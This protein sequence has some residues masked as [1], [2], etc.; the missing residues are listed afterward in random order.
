MG[1]LPTW[2]ENMR[3]VDMDGAAALLGVSRR[4]F[5]DVIREH[6]HF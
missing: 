6:R 5:V 1:A 4:T 3:P 2:A